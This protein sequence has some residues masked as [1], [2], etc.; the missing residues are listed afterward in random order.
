MAD[1]I[2]DVPGQGQVAFPDT[3]SDAEIAAAIQKMSPTAQTTPQTPENTIAQFLRGAGSRVA[4]IPGQLKTLATTNPLTTL[5]NMYESQLGQFGK[6]GSEFAQGRTSEGVGHIA[7]GLLPVL[8]PAAASIG[9]DIGS[10]EPSRGGSAAID[11]AMLALGSPTAR[12]GVRTVGRGAVG[13][14]KSPVGQAAVGAGVGAATGGLPGMVAG[15]AGGGAMGRL[16]QLLERLAPKAAEAEPGVTFPSPHARGTRYNAPTA[17]AG[18][19]PVTASGSTRWSPT[20]TAAEEPVTASGGVRWNPTATANEIPITAR[21]SVDWLPER[22]GP[23]PTATGSVRWSPTLTAGEVPITA[24]WRQAPNPAREAMAAFNRQTPELIEGEAIMPGGVAPTVAAPGFSL[25][26]IVE[27][28]VSS[29]LRAAPPH[30]AASEAMQAL[31]R[32]GRGGIDWRTTDAVPIDAL[33]RAK[34]ILEPGES[35][36]GLGERLATLLK[37]NDPAALVEAAQLAKALRQRMHIGESGR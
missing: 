17:T 3:M 5:K 23:E 16:A 8:G 24:S 27:A 15:A 14:A 34:T 30:E 19:E 32:T 26:D 22:A 12:A 13:A 4:E 11:A 20:A 28:P 25:G 29:R 1:Q 2:I 18:I 9:E 35:Q 10:A 33:R 7:A 37:S 6:A 36:L 21:G 31:Q